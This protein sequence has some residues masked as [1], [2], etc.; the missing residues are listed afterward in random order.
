MASLVTSVEASAGPADVSIEPWGSNVLLVEDNPGDARLVEHMLGD[1]RDAFHVHHVRRLEEAMDALQTQEFS[2]VL[3]DLSLPDGLGLETVKEVLG[4]A[5]SAPI[6]VLTGHSDQSLALEALQAGA[7]DYLTKGA[8]DDA[9]LLRSMRYAIERKRSETRLAY[10]AHHDQLTGLVNRTLFKERLE[11]ALARSRRNGQPVACLFLDLDRFKQ[12]NDNLGHEVGD[13][14]LVEVAKRIRGCVRS[15]ET[16]ARLG[17]DEFVVLLEGLEHPEAAELVAQR[18][19]AAM[20]APVKLGSAE[21]RV[22]TSIGIALSSPDDDLDQILERA[23]A[24]MYQA[25]RAGR[26]TYALA[27]PGQADEGGLQAEEIERALDKNELELFYQPKLELGTGRVTGVEALLR[28][29]H[30]R[31][32]D[33]APSDLLPLLEGTGRMVP[34][35]DWVL[36]RACRQARPWTQGAGFRL[37]VNVAPEQFDQEGLAAAV[38]DVLAETGFPPGALEL[39][40][41][42]DVLLRDVGRSRAVLAQLRSLGVRIALDD[43]NARSSLT[44]LAEFPLD[45]IKLDRSLIE[46]LSEA[47]AQRAIVAA[48]TNLAKNLN[49][50]T[51]A[52]GVETAA[53]KVS[54]RKLGCDAIQG[55]QVCQ[56]MDAAGLTVWLALREAELESER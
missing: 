55:Y 34:V 7:Q 2:L 38:A 4:A 35:G 54:L 12:I 13:Q 5:P 14:L 43:F 48:V 23:D 32:G 19:I 37:S 27:A 56:P 8:V 21:R 17:G 44:D 46:D 6:V 45:I 26:D 52:E 20:S 49:V 30:P 40:V 1:A 25:K 51:V 29:H 28:W 11:R 33:L 22:S 53:E 42:E 15:W 10:L 47:P 24:A 39:E 9:G 3:L 36:R 31:R 50:E 18:I 16:V 41:T